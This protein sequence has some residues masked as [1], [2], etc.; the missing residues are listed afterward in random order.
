MQYFVII[1]LFLYNIIIHKCLIVEN[2]INPSIFKIGLF[3][4]SQLNLRINNID[5]QRYIYNVILNCFD[6]DNENS[7]LIFD[8]Y[9]NSIGYSLL[10]LYSKYSNEFNEASHI[11]NGCVIN[12]NNQDKEILLHVSL[13][14]WPL[15]LY[16]IK[17]LAFIYDWDGK[18]VASRNLYLTS[19]LTNDY[20]SI[21]N[22]AL[23]APT[24]LW[25]SIQ[26]ENIYLRTL[27]SFYILLNNNSNDILLHNDLDPMLSM[28]EISLNPQYLGFSP[29]IIYE[30]FS[31]SL[32]KLYPSLD[33]N[34]I[35]I[36]NKNIISSSINKLIRIGVISGINYFYYYAIY[37]LY[38]FL[39]FFLYF[40][41]FRTF[42]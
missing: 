25:S 17:N 18:Y 14:L 4:N 40:T 23:S 30:L 6:N 1:L 32:I 24:L 13:A 15:N 19:V 39:I 41:L 21:I 31:L 10:E 9:N 27:F 11:A 5:T 16:S 26:S 42:F 7:L 36:S 28:R 12:K 33:I 38:L 20:G 37:N 8:V 22:L 35:P 2:E 34:Y 29:R 3:H